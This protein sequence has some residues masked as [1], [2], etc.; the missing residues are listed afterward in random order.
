MKKK[1]KKKAKGTLKQTKKG[2][3]KHRSALKEVMDFDAKRTK[4]KAV[5]RKKK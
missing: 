1:V 5:K 3:A 2:I 4:K